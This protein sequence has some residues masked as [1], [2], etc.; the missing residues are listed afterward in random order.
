M[1]TINFEQF[2]LFVEDEKFGAM[3]NFLHAGVRNE[4]FVMPYFNN[5]LV[6]TKVH[7]HM[8]LHLISKD[9]TLCK[10]YLTSSDFK[11]VLLNIMNAVN[12]SVD[13]IKS[14]L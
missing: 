12:K 7:A 8:E 5:H 6:L 10:W 4:A 1:I 13:I 2:S 14:S 11:R 9:N 3:L